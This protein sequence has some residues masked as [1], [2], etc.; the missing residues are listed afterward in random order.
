MMAFVSKYPEN[1]LPG[2]MVSVNSNWILYKQVA[3]VPKC[4]LGIY[5]RK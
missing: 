4:L 5:I 3:V 2:L 1:R